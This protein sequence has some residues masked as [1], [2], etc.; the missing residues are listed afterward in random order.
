MKLGSATSLDDFEFTTIVENFTNAFITSCT[1]DEIYLIK[2]DSW[3]DFKWRGFEG[4]LLGAL[5]TWNHEKL[6][7]PPFI[8]DRVVEQSYFERVDGAYKKHEAPDLHIYQSS[9][10]NI[11][12]KR[13]LVGSFGTRLLIWFSGNTAKSLR[14]SVMLYQIENDR[15]ATLYVS[16]LKKDKWQIFKTDGISR[17]EVLSII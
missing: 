8:P 17:N 16:F 15:H 12:G 11:T 4:K 1:P 10:D 3:F 7:I 6:K 2:I 9:S 14:G 13:R 5:G